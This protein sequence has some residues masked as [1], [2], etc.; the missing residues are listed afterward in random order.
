MPLVAL[1]RDIGLA[2]NTSH[3]NMSELTE[4]MQFAIQRTLQAA[5]QVSQV[6]ST[7][8]SEPSQSFAEFPFVIVVYMSA[9]VVDNKA[10]T[11]AVMHCCI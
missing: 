5:Q 4:G 8:Y 1:M 7:N 9:F 3:L 2:V 6:F 10:I 11:P